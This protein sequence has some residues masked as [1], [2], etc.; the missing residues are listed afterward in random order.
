MRN[1]GQE[2][3]RRRIQEHSQGI[4]LGDPLINIIVD[5]VDIPNAIHTGDHHQAVFLQ[6]EF[7]QFL[8]QDFYT[9]F[10]R[11]HVFW[12]FVQSLVV[13]LYG[14]VDF[15]ILLVYRETEFFVLQDD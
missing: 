1:H 4:P 6:L 10:Q 13:L 12:R 8:A 7:F 14:L 9:L 5:V 2:I 3:E 15:R 11:I